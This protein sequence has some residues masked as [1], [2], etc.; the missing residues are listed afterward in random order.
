MS[1]LILIICGFSALALAMKSAY[2]TDRSAESKPA[3]QS[4]SKDKEANAKSADSSSS[5]QPVARESSLPWEDFKKPSDGKL[6]HNLNAM[7]YH[8]TQQQGTEPAF[9]NRYWNNH[10]AGIYVDIVSGEPLFFVRRQV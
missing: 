9:K 6:R 1:K 2:S 5:T 7:Q 3:E 10:A 4:R 8:V